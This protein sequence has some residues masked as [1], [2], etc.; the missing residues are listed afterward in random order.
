VIA[1]SLYPFRILETLIAHTYRAV[2]FIV[3][4]EGMFTV[5]TYPTGL[6]HTPMRMRE[7]LI[8]VSSLGDTNCETCEIPWK[9][10]LSVGTDKELEVNVSLQF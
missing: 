8:I 7:Q 3:A 4:D 6:Y 2:N 1:T 5:Q 10:A 9:G